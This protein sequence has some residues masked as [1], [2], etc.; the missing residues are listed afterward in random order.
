[1]TRVLLVQLPI[2]RQNFGRKTGNV[3]LGAACLK[4]AVHNLSNV[5]VD[6]LPESLV[7]Y[8][9]DAALV[10]AIRDRPDAGIKSSAEHRT[11]SARLRKRG[12]GQDR[13]APAP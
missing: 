11:Q 13:F 9:A 5:E 6:I 3:P 2:P 1:M 12:W 7:S 10:E 4:Q 8:L